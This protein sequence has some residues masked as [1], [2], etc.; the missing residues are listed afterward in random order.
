[1]AATEDPDPVTADILHGFLGKLEKH[2]WM[3]RSQ[4]E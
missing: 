1:M 2:L 3:L 4:M